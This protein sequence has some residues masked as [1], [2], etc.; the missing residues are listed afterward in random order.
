VE[1][2]VRKIACVHQGYELY[3]SDRIFVMCVGFIRDLYPGAKIKVLIPKEGALS[4]TMRAEGY[5]VE[6]RDLWV[7]RRRYGLLGL[8]KRAL[9]L[10]R[11]VLLAR[12]FIAEHDLVYINTSVIVDFLLAARFYPGRSF[13]HVHEIP[14]KRARWIFRSLM[15]WSKCPLVYVSEAARA[16][17]MLQ[18]AN[19]QAVVH[20]GVAVQPPQVTDASPPPPLRVLL[21]GRINAGKG[22]SLLIEA[23]SLLPAAFRN[24]MAV[25][26]VGDVFEEARFKHD[27]ERQISVLGLGACVEIEGFRPD[28]AEAY[29][30]SNLVVIP[31][32][33]PESFGLVAAEAMSHA[34]AVLAAN[35]GGL[36]E[37]V[38]HD[39]TGWLFEAGDA[40]ELALYLAKAGSDPQSLVA[41]GNNGWRTYLDKFT[42]TVHQ[43][44]F[45]SF[46]KTL[47]SNSSK[48]T[49][50]E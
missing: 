15:R 4:S 50:G 25:R 40:R 30:W 39:F 28:P 20:N 38:H 43:Q 26:I 47:C 46:V 42:R 9:V 31:S 8:I 34:R 48:I 16:G 7:L 18:A 36:P 35:H 11:F 29:R 12:E 32:T 17:L 22:H 33:V 49:L 5:D 13:V 21:I 19:P 10:P 1:N 3:G 24:T 23:L 6:V 41:M 14:P 45:Q 37:V 2:S 27:L 44:N